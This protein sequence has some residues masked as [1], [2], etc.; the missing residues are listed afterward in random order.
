MND[1]NTTTIKT[2]TKPVLDS[3]LLR[4]LIMWADKDE[5]AI[6]H[7]AALAGI[8]W[9]Q[10]DWARETR[11]GVCKTACC[12]AGAAVLATGL[13]L[14]FEGDEGEK[15]RTAYGCAP[16]VPSDELDDKGKPVM[17]PDRDQFRSINMGGRQALGLTEYEADY[18]FNGDNDLATVA[19]IAERIAER[20]GI[21]LSLPTKLHDLA[22]TVHLCRTDGDNPCVQKTRGSDMYEYDV[23]DKYMGTY[24]YRLMDWD[25]PPEA[26][27]FNQFDLVGG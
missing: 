13:G 12:I 7:K 26:H 21:N 17:V 5:K 25:N 6:Q 27:E 20:R 8:K 11:N 23:C 19:A 18:L 15:S 9:D 3:F 14:L 24:R 10:S 2:K 22:R 1:T 4:D 16:L